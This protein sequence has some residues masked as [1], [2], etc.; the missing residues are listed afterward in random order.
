ML[1]FKARAKIVESLKGRI[2][3]SKAAYINMIA[4]RCRTT[5]G[6]GLAMQ[7]ADFREFHTSETV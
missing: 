4:R 7:G 2:P 1:A 3:Q 5:I 6:F